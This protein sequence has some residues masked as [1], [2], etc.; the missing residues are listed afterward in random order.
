MPLRLPGSS[1]LVWLD[2]TIGYNPRLVSLS[3][4]LRVA[5]KPSPTFIAEKMNRFSVLI[6]T[7]LLS[8]DW[9]GNPVLGGDAASRIQRIPVP[10]QPLVT[11]GMRV[12]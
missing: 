10:A 12:P 1:I 11:Q 7:P 8:T 6:G 2:A 9:A 5:V 3:L 4:T